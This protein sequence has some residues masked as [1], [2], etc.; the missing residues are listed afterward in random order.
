MRC[1]SF[2]IVVSLIIT[3]PFKPVFAQEK[4]IS[5]VPSRVESDKNNDGKVDYWQFYTDGKLEKIEVDSDFDGT[6][7]ETIY[8]K[9]G[10]PY[11]GERDTDKDGIADTWLYY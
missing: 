11:K 2:L 3:A 5:L 1:T 7:D 6:V 4:A 10:K 8:F 9:D